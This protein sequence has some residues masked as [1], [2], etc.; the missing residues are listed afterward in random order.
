MTQIIN[1]NDMDMHVTQTGNIDLR[2]REG[3]QLLVVA[4][5]FV[6]RQQ[7]QPRPSS[8][9]LVRFR[10]HLAAPQL[11]VTHEGVSKT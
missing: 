7:P 1:E 2:E 11:N 9:Y 3:T 8:N 5:V 6:S 10:A 4:D